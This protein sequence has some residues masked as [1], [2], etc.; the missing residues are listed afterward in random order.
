MNQAFIL[1]KKALVHNDVPIGAVI[2]KDGKVI[3]SSHNKKEL[4]NDIFVE[5]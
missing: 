2:V 3:T 5:Y 4:T 1:A